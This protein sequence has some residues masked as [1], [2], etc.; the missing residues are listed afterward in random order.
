MD[1]AA[2]IEQLV[3]YITSLSGLTA[4]AVILGILF[5]CG[6]GV[7][8]P[9]D[10]TLVSAGILA[11]IGNISLAGAML[12]CFFGVMFGDAFLYT[13]GRVYGRKV[14]EAPFVRNILTPERVLIAEKKVLENSGFICF[15]ARFLPGL[16][17]P[18][19]LMSGVL[20]VRPIVFYGLDGLAALISVPVWVLV[21]WWFGKN[22]DEAMAFA[23]S[24]QK[25]VIAGLVVAIVGYITYRY[26]KKR[27][28]K[29]AADSSVEH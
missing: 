20:G 14:L 13:I 16:R 3:N 5:G 19:F 1:L 15:T 21:G 24:M 10:I 6:M 27:R 12:V 11:G 23:K 18:V 25:Y 22:I 7:P 8:I 29:V 9:E 28:S 17:S 26:W 4:Y 2:L